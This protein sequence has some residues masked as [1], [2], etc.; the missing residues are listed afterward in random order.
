MLC[1][2]SLSVRAR[3]RGRDHLSNVRL[4]P[5]TAEDILLIQISA[6]LSG[7]TRKNGREDQKRGPFCPVNNCKGELD[8]KS[9]NQQAE[10]KKSQ[11]RE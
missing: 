8:P 5:Y 1:T 3:K 9:P 4:A 6:A 7:N 11:E 10:R 2:Y